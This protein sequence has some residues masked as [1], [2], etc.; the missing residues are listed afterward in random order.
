ME[1]VISSDTNVI[2]GSCSKHTSR[3]RRPSGEEQESKEEYCIFELGRC[4]NVIKCE[5]KSVLTPR[6][7]DSAMISSVLNFSSDSTLSR[8]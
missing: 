1:L 3:G 5:A 2:C 4:V 7:G 6:S 8:R